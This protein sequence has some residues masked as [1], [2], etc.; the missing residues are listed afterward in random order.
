MKRLLVVSVIALAGLASQAN[1]ADLGRRPYA[2]PA[3][4]YNPIYNWTGLY[5]G[6]NGGG[7]WGDSSW[8]G[9]SSGNINASGGLIGGTLGYNWQFGQTVVGIETDLQW[10]D[11]KGSGACAFG[12]ETRNN[13][14]G[15]VRGRLGYAWDRFMPYITGG[16]AYGNVEANPSFGFVSNDTTNAGWALGGG[17]EFAL[18]QNWTAKVEY[19]HYDLGNFTC[20]TCAFVPTSVNF[21]AD[22][23]RGGINYRF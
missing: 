7:G 1:A 4:V 16:L 12:C 3:P 6:V 21:S 5:V 23:V 22:V 10:S 8:S 15:T 9:V 14:F 19:L 13:W 18:A 11:I 20:T 2:A 17:V